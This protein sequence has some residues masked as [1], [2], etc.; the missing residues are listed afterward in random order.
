[1]LKPTKAIA[2][3]ALPVAAA[4]L[5]GFAVVSSL[6]PGRAQSEPEQPPQQSASF[7]SPVAGIGVVEPSSELIAVASELPGVARTVHVKAGDVVAKGAPLFSLDARALQAQLEAAQAGAAQAEAAAQAASV[8]LADERHRLSLFEAVE[9]KRAIS[10]D[11]LARRRFAVERAATA[12]AQAEAAARAARAQA[13]VVATDLDRLTVRAP[14][15][16]RVWRV[17][18]R[19][20]EFAA[21]GLTQEPLVSMGAGGPLHVRVE[22]D[23]ADISRV[24]PG[25]RAEGALRGSA[26]ARLPLTFV[27]FEPEAVEKRALAGGAERVDT[28][29]IEVI[30]AIAAEAKAEPTFIGQRMDVFV[31]AAAPATAGAGVESGA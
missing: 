28:R 26:A 2:R 5:F 11:E 15:A 6:R 3:F 20:G 23:E 27:R 12:L 21:A 31:E 13:R 24:A 1:M 16:G 19:P 14:I 30:Y 29:V 22:I 4:G 18:V 7:K 25:A 10:A 17:N 9:D 8:A